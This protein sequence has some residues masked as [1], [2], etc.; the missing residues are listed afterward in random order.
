[1]A[2]LHG[3]TKPSNPLLVFGQVIR[4]E[5]LKQGLSQDELADR[6]GLDR[7]YI[8]GVE[9]GERNVSLLNILKLAD[10]LKLPPATL[11]RFG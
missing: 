10:A 5:R 1:M 11:F 9:R 2:D 7:S 4:T 8:G 3:V 6:A